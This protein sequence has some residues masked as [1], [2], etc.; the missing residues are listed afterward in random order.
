MDYAT[1]VSSRVGLLEVKAELRRHGWT[2]E[3]AEAEGFTKD[4]KPGRDGLYSGAK[5]LAWLG[6]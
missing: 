5:V 6:Y 4:V 1:A 3:A 2:W